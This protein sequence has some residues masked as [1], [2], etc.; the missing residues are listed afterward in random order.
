[1]PGEYWAC[2]C[3]KAVVL[4]FVEGVVLG[5]RGVRFCL[6]GIVRIGCRISFG[7]LCMS[8]DILRRRGFDISQMTLH[9][10]TER[11]QLLKYDT[12]YASPK[13]EFHST[14]C[15]TWR[16]SSTNP[17][18]RIFHPQSAVRFG[19]LIPPPPPNYSKFTANGVPLQTT[20]VIPRSFLRWS[21]H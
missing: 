15:S 18:V 11:R 8:R 5:G 6:D 16:E 14:S 4:D 2:V 3:K 9:F 10:A 1:M 17:S 12:D 21:L 13:Q 7:I 19:I 20:F